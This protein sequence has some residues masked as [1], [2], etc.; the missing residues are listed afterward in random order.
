[1]KVRLIL[2]PVVCIGALLSAVTLALTAT[3]L[4]PETKLDVITRPA[5]ANDLKPIDC[6]GIDL[7]SLVVG[8]GTVRGT[9]AN[10]LILASP[11]SDRVSGQGGNDCLVG[12]GGNDQLTGG[13]GKDVCLGGPGTDVYS[14]C[15]TTVD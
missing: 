4:V 5:G 12:G 15:E 13:A 11:T 3:V 7:Q 14:G 8:S 10:D 6:V 9:P 1:M 2:A